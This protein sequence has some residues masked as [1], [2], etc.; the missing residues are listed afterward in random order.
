LGLIQQGL[1][2]DQIAERLFVTR[3]TVKFHLKV[4]YLK[5]GVRPARRR[6]GV[7]ALSRLDDG[8]SVGLPVLI[9]K[10]SS[11]CSL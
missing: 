5:L 8:E 2:N 6:I 4:L 9:I 10:S 7:R 1:T 11:A 3:N